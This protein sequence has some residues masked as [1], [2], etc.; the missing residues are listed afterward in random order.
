MSADDLI[1]GLTI[2]SSLE[3]PATVLAWD[4]PVN[5]VESITIVR[6]KFGYSANETDGTAIYY[7]AGSHSNGISDRYRETLLAVI[8]TVIDNSITVAVNVGFYEGMLIY[9]KENEIIS[10]FY[11]TSVSGT[12]IGL[13]S[14]VGSI[15][16]TDATVYSSQVEECTTYYYTIFSETPVATF[17]SNSSARDYVTTGKE[18]F[19]TSKLYQMLPDIYHKGDRYVT[20]SDIVLALSTDTDG[21]EFN[22]NSDGFTPIGPL[23]RYLKIIGLQL[24]Q[25]KFLLDC[26]SSHRDIDKTSIKFLSE[27][28]RFL[29][30]EFNRE[31]SASKQRRELKDTVQIY[32]LKGTKTAL[33]AFISNI[34]DA[35]PTIKEWYDNLFAFYPCG[36]GFF[37]Y[38]AGEIAN[39]GTEDDVA[40]YFV[41]YG[42]NQVVI[43]PYGFTVFFDLTSLVLDEATLN[44]L[45]SKLIEYSPINTIPTM[46]GSLSFSEAISIAPMDSV[47]Y[48][49]FV[50]DNFTLYFSIAGS[51]SYTERVLSTEYTFAQ[52]SVGIQD[53][54]SGYIL[55]EDGYP[56]IEE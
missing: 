23:E 27:F 36:A 13:D 25:V 51:P 29:G 2:R 4:S 21:E 38:T 56:L 6:R 52:V 10:S 9:I 26:I 37:G 30:F 42:S 11:I 8:T 18:Q 1:T 44:K 33:G 16:S 41:E 31:L 20:N 12:T 43:N 34:V 17:L 22:I 19:F 49:V 53:E 54:Y 24:D 32:K 39:I 3:G 14:A 47:T 15:F 5:S 46:Q 50:Q 28:A 40:G 7:K 55:G 45:Q 35:N 48:A